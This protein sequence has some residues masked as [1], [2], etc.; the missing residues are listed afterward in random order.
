MIH[1]GAF[2]SKDLI[3]R[4]L[5]FKRG[6]G[7]Y[8]FIFKL[9]N[10]FFAKGTCGAAALFANLVK[11]DSLKV[12]DVQD[13]ILGFEVCSVGEWFRK[14]FNLSIFIIIIIKA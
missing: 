9:I 13:E 14:G 1:L 2:S 8:D 7:T 11:W 12:K 6:L 10:Q 5:Y 3:L 4:I